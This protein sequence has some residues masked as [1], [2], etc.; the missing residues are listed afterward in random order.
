[1][2]PNLTKVLGMPQR[3]GD[4]SDVSS[5]FAEIELHAPLLSMASCVL[6]CSDGSYMYSDLDLE[7]EEPV[8]LEGKEPVELSEISLPSVTLHRVSWEEY[9]IMAIKCC[10][11]HT[12]HMKP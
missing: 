12:F 11:F 1:M 9:P 8:D 7:G 10:N 6:Q 4:A 3:A 5:S 2:R